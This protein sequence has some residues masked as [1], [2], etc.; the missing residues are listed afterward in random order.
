MKHTKGEWKV[1]TNP[2]LNEMY[3]WVTTVQIFPW[4]KMPIAGNKTIICKVFGGTKENCGAN[5]K[6]IATAPEL[7]EAC[8]WSVKQFKIL[9]DKG[10]YPEHLLAKNN[11]KG[12]SIITTAIKK[13]T[14]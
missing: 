3:T 12:F 8:L 4:N 5:A 10:Q 13:A 9:A 11:G 1:K 14:Q 7:L 2:V 6:L